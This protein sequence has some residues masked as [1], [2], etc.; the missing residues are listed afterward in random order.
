M[1]SLRKNHR[2][3]I[4]LPGQTDAVCTDHV[5]VNYVVNLKIWIILNTFQITF[6]GKFL[7]ILSKGVTILIGAIVICDIKN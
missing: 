4:S 3:G 6:K 2:G 7:F 1:K 5:H